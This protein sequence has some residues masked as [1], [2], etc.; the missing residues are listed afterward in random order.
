MRQKRREKKFPRNEHNLR[1]H[2]RN[3]YNI[4]V[5]KVSFSS[6]KYWLETLQGTDITE[7]FETHHYNPMVVKM[8]P[9]F[10]VRDAK[11]E[12][13]SP[14]TFNENGFY[15]TLKRKVQKLFNLNLI[16]NQYMCLINICGKSIVCV[17]LCVTIWES[18]FLT[19]FDKI[20][21]GVQSGHG[22]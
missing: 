7:A 15:K 12:R 5:I 19:H 1:N 9:K 8:L 21:Q 13:N 17:W 4:V 10:Y 16:A 20:W 6:G 11:I 14:Y 2:L 3:V 18:Q 22:V